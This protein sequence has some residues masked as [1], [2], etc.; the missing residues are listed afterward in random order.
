MQRPARE[1]RRLEVPS[2]VMIR[3]LRNGEVDGDRRQGGMST[4]H[5]RLTAGSSK[6]HDCVICLQQFRNNRP[7]QC[8]RTRLWRGPRLG[9]N[10]EP[11]KSTAKNGLDNHMSVKN[12]ISIVAVFAVSLILSA[13]GGSKEESV[14]LQGA[15]P[16]SR[17]LCISSG[18][19]PIVLRI[20]MS[21]STIN[22]WA[23]EAA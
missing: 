12:F 3:E 22:R 19:N 11:K 2:G 10:R 20:P 9:L 21:R 18:S 7:L 17:H 15:E 4:T 1:G 5:W 14:K 23:A 16:A 13:C 6:S 8:V